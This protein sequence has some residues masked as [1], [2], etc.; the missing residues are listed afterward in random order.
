VQCQV[1][2][3]HRD[4]VAA[5]SDVSRPD[6][7]CQCPLVQVLR[8]PGA[9]RVHGLVPGQFQEL[10]G[11]PIPG[12]RYLFPSRR[13]GEQSG[14]LRIDVRGQVPGE[15]AGTVR[16]IKLPEHAERGPGHVEV[17]ACHPQPARL[18]GGRRGL[19]R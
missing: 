3:V 15:A 17:V 14:Q 16:V 1:P 9:A 6:R 19:S 5:I 10:G 18:P 4:Q 11:Q 12:R 7:R 2:Q 8:G 13:A